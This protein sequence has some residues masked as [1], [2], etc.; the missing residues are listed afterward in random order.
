VPRRMMTQL[1]H[2]LSELTAT[3]QGSLSIISGVNAVA[4]RWVLVQTTL[5]SWL[6]TV[7]SDTGY[8]TCLTPKRGEQANVV[9]A[10]LMGEAE[11][12][13]SFATA[14]WLGSSVPSLGPKMTEEEKLQRDLEALEKV[15]AALP[16]GAGTT[17]RTERRKRKDGAEASSSGVS[18]PPPPT[19]P[20]TGLE[21]LQ[22]KTRQLQASAL[23]SQQ[24]ATRKRTA[25]RQQELAYHKQMLE[26]LEKDLG[27][28][29]P[30]KPAP[31]TPPSMS[32]AA[33]AEEVRPT[34]KPEKT[35]EQPEVST[36]KGDSK[37]KQWFGAR[38][39]TFDEALALNRKRHKENPPTNP[40]RWSA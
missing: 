5:I 14:V 25:Q 8:V 34:P 22:A 7:S 31:T 28:L 27:A 37:P 17:T 38:I 13:S 30:R 39:L 12:E 24:E 40:G 2:T 18:P 1:V 20:M 10:L 26:S 3:T 11:V 32:S 23:I 6:A 35:E 36:P 4:L 19:C 21:A 9:V 15:A 33:A 16:T 29:A